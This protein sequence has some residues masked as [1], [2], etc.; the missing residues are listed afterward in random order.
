MTRDKFASQALA[1][2][3][4]KVKTSRVLMVGAGGIGCELLKNLVLTGFG[5][6]ELVD[7]DTIDLSNLN[8]QFLFGNEH[9]K[10]SKALVAKQT[11]GRFNPDVELIAHHADIKAGEFNVAWFKRFD[12]V[13]N[14]LDNLDA[15]R[16]VN[17]MCLTADVPLIESGTTGFNGQVQVI[18]RGQTECYDC[19]PKPV[20]KSFPVCTIRTTPSQPIHCIV[21]AKM[22]LFSQLFGRDDEASSSTV[23]NTVTD[24]NAAEIEQ[25]SKEAVELKKVKD[26][27]GSAEFARLVFAKVFQADIT[28]LRD[29]DGAWND[30]KAPDPLI[31]DEVSVQAGELNS[32]ASDIADNDQPVWTVA[33]SFKVFEH[34]IARLVS[35][36]ASNSTGA[37]LE[38][39]KD[40]DDTLDF[41]VAAA[42]LRASVFGIERKSKFDVKQMAGNIIPAIATT[43]AIV[44]GLCVLQGFKVIANDLSR[45]RSIFLSSRPDQVFGAEQLARPNPQCQVCGVARA[46]VSLNPKTVTLERFVREIILKN[47]EYS[48]DVSIVTDKLLWDV[49]FDDNANK[50]LHE[51][52][53]KDGVFVTVIDDDDDAPKVNLEILISEI[54][55]DEI[56]VLNGSSEIPLRPSSKLVDTQAEAQVQALSDNGAKRK[57]EEEEEEEEDIGRTKKVKVDEVIDLDKDEAISID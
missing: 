49:E 2:V 51:V 7:L 47:F 52:G 27:F 9:I 56:R 19:V 55:E 20:P 18:V 34:S 15:R 17:R 22:Y 16:H 11:A 10:K 30:R 53:V 1:N 43:N 57:A 32:T 38:F 28:R 8:R 26:A 39:D 44:A 35:R 46:A 33:E 6:I 48:D 3:Y 54:S 37:G 40:D 41:V 4:D 12:V 31:Y 45:A 23:D 50:T 5:T 25:L 36:A 24:D 13:F 29:M 14:A 21:W 42:N